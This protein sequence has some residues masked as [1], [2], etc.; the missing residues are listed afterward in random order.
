MSKNSKKLDS[1]CEKG[2]ILVF[3]HTKDVYIEHCLHSPVVYGDRVETFE[4]Y[5][6]GYTKDANELH[7]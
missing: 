5:Y 3:W 6:R 4:P 2:R 7:Y 1:A